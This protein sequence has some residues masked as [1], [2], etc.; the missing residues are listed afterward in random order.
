M[1]VLSIDAGTTGVRA[2]VF[3]AGGR[4]VSGAYREFPQHFPMPGLIEHDLTEIWD[5]V[6]KVV[7]ESIQ[8]AGDD[9]IEAIGI[10]NQRETACAWSR[11]DGRPRG[12]AIVWQDRRT[13]G[14]CDELRARG[15]EPLIRAKTGLVLDP[16][17]TS[18]KFEWMLSEGGLRDD[19]DLALGTIDS[20]VLFKLTGGKVHSTDWSN[21]SRTMLFD[22]DSQRWDEELCDL[23]H[24]PERALPE[25]L[26]SSA[27]FGYSDP[28]LTGGRSLP[29][30]GIA[31]DQ[32]A[33][34]FGQA[35]L[36]PGMS[37]NTYGTGSFVLMN[38]GCERPPTV[39]G[40]LTTIAWGIGG[41]PVFAYEG[42]I[43][44]T[45]S[46]IQ[47]LR[48][49]IGVISEAEEAGPLAESVGDTGDVYFVPAFA[50]LGS[51]WWD[52][53]ARG[54]LVGITRGTGRPEIVR[55]VVESMA[56]QTRDVV[57]AMQESAGIQ[58]DEL[59]VDGGASAMNFLCQFQADQLGIPVRRASV[60]ETTA[61]G[62][63]YLAGITVGVWPTTDAVTDN[64]Q[65]DAT[66]APRTE[67]QAND[68]SYGRWLEALE[69]SRSWVQPG[70]QAGVGG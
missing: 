59:R 47:W 45:G 63:A 27:V 28:E 11:S 13:A 5:A 18:T 46:A 55:A 26:P 35:C 60:Q 4:P 53:Y 19:G 57:A 37:K 23:F 31:G 43:F 2:I 42:A 14:R 3:G 48:D 52:P 22:L 10:T 39:D 6:R 50:G 38:A 70:S 25:P 17:F 9:D 65:A 15:A 7:T 12:R 62:A 36:E 24:V 30:A 44:S 61:L 32:Q 68:R 29:I 41:E 54:V 66:F 67:R 51:P 49:G 34:L 21:A 16:Y 33:S 1:S 20:W 8:A 69:R 40:L 64:W 58:V 56:F